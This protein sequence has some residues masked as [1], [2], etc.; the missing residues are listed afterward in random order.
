MAVS[1][2]RSSVELIDCGKTGPQ[3]G[4]AGTGRTRRAALAKRA[5][6]GGEE[7]G[8]GGGGREEKG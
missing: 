2:S 4:E 6:G 1:L 3:P 5:E 8:E 7:R